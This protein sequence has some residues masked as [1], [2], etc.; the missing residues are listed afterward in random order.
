[1]SGR[2]GDLKPG[3]YTLRRDMSNGAAL[4]ALAAGPPPNIVTI[5]V[6]EGRSRREIAGIVGDQLEGDYLAATRRSPALDP[7]EYGAKGASSLEGFLFPATFELK[8]GRPVSELVTQQLSAFRRE[9]DQVDLRYAHSKNLT[10]Y[11][12]LIIASMVERE[13]S[14]PRERPLIA[15][16]IYNRLRQ[17][18]PLG[19]DATLRFALNQW[20]RPLT[21]SELASPSPYN[22]RS[23]PGPAAGADRQ[24]RHRLDQGRGPSGPHGL[25]LLRGQAGRRRGARVRAHR[26]RAPAQRGALQ[27]RPRGPRRPL[28]RLMLVAYGVLGWPVGHSRSPAMLR[29]AFRELGLDWSYL[30]LPVPPELFEETVRALPASGYAGANVTVP[31]KLAAHALCDGLSDTARAIGAV[32]TLTFRPGRIEGEN[33]D[34]PGLL[35]AIGEPVAG[36]RALVLGAGGAGRAAAW[37]LREAGAEVS[38]WN[39]TA[40]ARGG[41]SPT[42]WGCGTPGA[43]EPADLLVNSTSVGLEP[44]VGE[45]GGAGRARAG[46]VGA[47]GA[48]RGPGLRRASR[49]PWCAGPS[50]SGSRT[51][52]GLEVLVHQGARSLALWT[53]AD[54]PLD[55]MKEAA[56]HG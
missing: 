33:T 1:M 8:R 56:R 21:E 14:I 16:V 30:P 41:R 25:S 50:R 13:A 7:R 51:I 47:P 39:R 31:H 24:S 46:G 20:E 53:G 19:I 15:S 18:I 43:A 36:R 48:R 28:A 27:Q 17:G 45:H 37:A 3:S 6:P 38:I 49:R 40:G 10:D 26:R 34:A 54:P 11:D 12:V 2:R 35:D 44:G 55:V 52:D 9:F 23:T 4:D 22:T 42:S 5:T 32:N 29:A